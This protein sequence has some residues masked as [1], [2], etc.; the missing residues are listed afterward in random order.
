MIEFEFYEY[1]SLIYM[2]CTMYAKKLNYIYLNIKQ[3]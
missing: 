3:M 1:M 2:Y